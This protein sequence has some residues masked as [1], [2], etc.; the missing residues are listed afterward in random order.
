MKDICFTKL[1]TVRCSEFEL[2]TKDFVDKMSQFIINDV[3]K[4]NV[5]YDENNDS[6]VIKI[7]GIN[8]LAIYG[9]E[10]LDSNCFDKTI[11]GYL[12]KLSVLS[13]IQKELVDEDN[14]RKKQ[15]N[16]R[17]E[18]LRYNAKNNILN[19]VEEMKTKIDLLKEEYNEDKT[20]VFSSFINFIKETSF[21]EIS[22]V[23]GGMRALLGIVCAIVLFVSIMIMLCDPSTYVS[24][25][26]P[27][28]CV[29][30]SL[31]LVSLLI[32]DNVLI[33]KW[34][35]GVHRSIFLLLGFPFI[36]ATYAIKRLK[37][38]ISLKNSIDKVKKL[39]KQANG[40]KKTKILNKNAHVDSIINSLNQINDNKTITISLKEFDEL[41]DDILNIKDENEKKQCFSELYQLVDNCIKLSN[42]PVKEKNK[43]YE[44]LL[45]QLDCLKE[46]V[47]E[48]LNKEENN[49]YKLMT[50][51]NEKIEETK[52]EEYAP[53]KKIGRR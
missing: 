7:N 11:L 36:F 1:K 14:E 53:Q 38:K 47:K 48:A 30:P 52:T 33:D 5:F 3:E 29:L 35:T 15:A 50:E 41:K 51:V 2:V 37:E 39:I 26:I 20:K 46:K 45:R 18:K 44:I 16:E 13:S 32:Y 40:T 17:K 19:T 10:K 12:K 31:D 4:N 23:N 9:N 22:E 28:A 42:K 34:Y 8:Y 43:T 25:W 21:N 27:V 6:F 24:I 49:Y